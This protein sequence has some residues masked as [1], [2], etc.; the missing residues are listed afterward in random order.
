MNNKNYTAEEIMEILNEKHGTDYRYMQKDVFED[1]LSELQLTY[2]KITNPLKMGVGCYGNYIIKAKGNYLIVPLGQRDFSHDVVQFN[3]K[4]KMTEEDY[5]E[6]ETYLE[7]MK[8]E[9]MVIEEVK[10]SQRLRKM[11]Q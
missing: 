8:K 6:L 9:M 5:I 11:F 3:R 7:R 2:H 10:E 4:R 1:T